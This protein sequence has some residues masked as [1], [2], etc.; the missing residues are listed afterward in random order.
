MVIDY[1]H[2]SARD[3]ASNLGL[4]QLPSICN[5]SRPCLMKD[6]GVHLRLRKASEAITLIINRYTLPNAPIGNSIASLECVMSMVFSV[7]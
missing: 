1:K 2:L 4:N 6:R 3:T 7:G 5:S